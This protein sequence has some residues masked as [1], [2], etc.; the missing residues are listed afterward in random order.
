M[1]KVL[2][3]VLRLLG[4]RVGVQGVGRGLKDVGATS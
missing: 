3:Y 4:L 1:S 2:L